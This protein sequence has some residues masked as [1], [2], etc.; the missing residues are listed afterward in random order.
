MLVDKR[1][2]GEG[3]RTRGGGG[4]GTEVDVQGVEEG[5]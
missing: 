4:G 2:E 5:G 1:S 3:L